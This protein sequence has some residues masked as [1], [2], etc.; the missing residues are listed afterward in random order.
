MD[1]AGT[2]ARAR[3]GIL[4]SGCASGGN[5][6]LRVQWSAR[7]ADIGAVARISVVVAVPAV[8]DTEGSPG[9]EGRDAGKLPSTQWI[10]QPTRASSWN[11]PQIRD[12]KA[13]WPVEITHAAIQ[14]QSAPHDRNGCPIHLVRLLQVRKSGSLAGA[15]DELRPGI[16][17]RQLESVGES[18]IEARL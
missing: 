16:G 18:A 6:C 2:N 14:L 4:I 8:S 9:L 10:P 17:C 11:R 3:V 15:V 12:G 7:I 13:L 5:N 1:V